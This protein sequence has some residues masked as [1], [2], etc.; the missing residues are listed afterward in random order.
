MLANSIQLSTFQTL[1]AAEF[2]DRVIRERGS[3]ENNSPPLST[4]LLM[5]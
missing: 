5:I 3:T 1:R 2:R 4:G